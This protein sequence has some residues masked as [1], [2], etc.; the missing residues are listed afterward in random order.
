MDRTRALRG[1][2]VRGI[3]ASLL[4]LGERGFSPGMGFHVVVSGFPLPTHLLI[5]CLFLAAITYL[6]FRSDAPGLLVAAEPTRVKNIGDLG[7]LVAVRETPE[8]SAASR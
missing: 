1:N 4:E 3:L 7:M 5:H 6:L 2:G 8:I